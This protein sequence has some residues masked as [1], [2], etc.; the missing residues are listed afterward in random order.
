MRSLFISLDKLTISVNSPYV[1]ELPQLSSQNAPTTY[2]L[3]SQMMVEA[4]TLFSL[5]FTHIVGHTTRYY[6]ERTKAAAMDSI[7]TP[8]VTMRSDSSLPRSCLRSSIQV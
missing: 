2:Y 4:Q 7:Y 8:P 3:H 1:F 5:G 6:L